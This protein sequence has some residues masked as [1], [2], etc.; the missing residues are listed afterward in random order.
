MSCDLKYLIDGVIL[1][2]AKGRLA[3][4][5]ANNRVSD[6]AKVLL[7]LKVQYIYAETRSSIC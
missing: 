6:T 5:K 2:V 7:H 3:H 1:A 4:Q